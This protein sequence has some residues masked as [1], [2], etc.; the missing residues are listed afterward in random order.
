LCLGAESCRYRMDILCRNG[1]PIEPSLRGRQAVALRM[2]GRQAALVAEVDLPARP[3]RLRLGEH[4]IGL[5]RGVPSGEQDPEDRSL[6][7]RRPGRGQDSPRRLGGNVRRILQ[8]TSSGR[9][10]HI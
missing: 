3:V 1:Y 8:D 2:I 6:R 7:D 9:A 4:P 10:T 5:R